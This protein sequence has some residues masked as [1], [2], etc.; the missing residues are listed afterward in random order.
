M[1]SAYQEIGNQGK[2]SLHFSRAIDSNPDFGLAYGRLGTLLANRGDWAAAISRFK[3]S[4]D[5]LPRDPLTRN[6]LGVALLS[7]GRLSEAERQF[8]W[9]IEIEE[10]ADPHYNLGTLYGSQRQWALAELHLRRAISIRPIFTLAVN[11]LGNVFA[12]QAR[13]EEAAAQFAR[14]LEIDPG[15]TSAREA[16][17]QVQ[18]ILSNQQE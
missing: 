6:N 12:E 8:K 17:R 1:A 9:A 2:A 3:K 7:E 13:W 11:D 15:F 4:L 14:A 18:S 16:L 5:L 10:F